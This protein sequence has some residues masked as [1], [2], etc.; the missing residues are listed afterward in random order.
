MGNI[1][2]QWNI[3]ENGRQ[4][5]ICTEYKTWDQF[6]KNAGNSTGYANVCKF[7][8]YKLPYK[9]GTSQC[10]RSEA[11]KKRDP[12]YKMKEAIRCRIRSAMKA[13]KSNKKSSTRELIGCSNEELKKWLEDKF[14]PHPT[15]G[16]PMTFEN[17]GFGFNKWHI[18]H[19]EPLSKFDMNDPEQQ[20][21]A[22]HFSNLQ[23]MWQPENFAKDKA[24]FKNFLKKDKP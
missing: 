23:P 8:I 4:C 17:H 9:S 2:K 1:R 11:R 7:C 10:K 5:R 22:N 12:A 6:N 21:K 13:S 16:E 19:K 15:T 20:K 24:R 18:D 14:Y 3:D